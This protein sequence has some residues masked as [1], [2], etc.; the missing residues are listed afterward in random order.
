MTVEQVIAV[1]GA[2]T[3]LLAAIGTLMIQVR[4][5][6]D[7]VNGRLTQLLQE[8]ETAARREGELAGRDFM[9]RLMQGAPAGPDP[10]V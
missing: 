6:H 1:L 10:K 8:R 7:A 3:A 5:L 4:A 2:F 9:R